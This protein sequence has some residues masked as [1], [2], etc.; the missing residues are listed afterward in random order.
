MAYQTGKTIEYVI[1]EIDSKKY[2]LPS[3]QREF[4]WNTEQI[5]TLFDS[6]MRGYPI[7]SFLF[8]KVK[9][10]KINEYQFYN[11]LQEYS[12]QDIY[13]NLKA[14][15]DGKEEIIAILDGQQ[16][17]TSL[18]LGLKGTYASKIRYKRIDNPMNY[19][20][21]ILYLNLF[22]DSIKEGIIYDFAFLTI[23]EY[24]KSKTN[25]EEFYFRIGDIFNYDMAKIVDFADDNFDDVDK[26]LRKAARNRLLR[27]HEMVVKDLVI[28][29]YQEEE[30]D[31]D[32]VLNIFVRT[33]AGGT[34]LAYS[35]LLLSIASSQWEKDAREEIIGLVNDINKIGNGFSVDKDFVLKS[36]LVLAD[37]KSVAFRVENFKKEN[38][39]KI[40]DEWDDIKASLIRTF[41][42]ISS[43]GYQGEN[44]PSNNS[45]IPIA[46]YIHHKKM[47]Y[48]LL[49]K[50]EYSNHR[51][52]IQDW[53]AIALLKRVFGGQPD[54]VLSNTRTLIQDS[55]DDLFPSKEII[56]DYK[57]HPSKSFTFDKLSIQS[58]IDSS[59]YGNKYTFSLLQFLYPSFDFRNKFHMDHIHPRS[60]ANKNK[61]KNAGVDID[62]DSF[63]H[64]KNNINNLS[65]LQLLDGTINIEKSDTLFDIWVNLQFNNENEKMNYME[66][67]YIPKNM[68]LDIMNFE[69]FIIEREKLIFKKL[70]SLL[71]IK[72]EHV[73]LGES[74]D[75]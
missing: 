55:I 14:N 25:D 5:E 26:E 49:S 3:I 53:L 13:S 1:E 62:S 34:K 31:L 17:L 57:T 16:R 22:E 50:S 46:Y 66:K 68:K 15:V 56:E 70:C 59:K 54:N 63:I 69:N 45:V 33:N 32:K 24:E 20:K 27:L 60:Y 2:L 39:K 42:L 51:K 43:F 35:D 72:K 71:L 37:I 48:K 44:L 52:V 4:V 73:D 9:K 75:G 38:M 61:L 30:Q 36:S 7:N 23:D 18:Y 12:E 10:S 21:R 29:D 64:F 28:F 41:E 11:F 40:E 58:L 47:N 6:L 8:W 19:P 65:N 74:L 67:H